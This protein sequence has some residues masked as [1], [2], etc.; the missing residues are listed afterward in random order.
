MKST[1]IKQYLIDWNYTRKFRV[2]RNDT[3]H[4][5]LDR[6]ESIRHGPKVTPCYKARSYQTRCIVSVC[7]MLVGDGAGGHL[8]AA[9]GFRWRRLVLRSGGSDS[10]P[11]SPSPP[12]PSP[13]PDRRLPPIRLQVLVY[14]ATQL[15]HTSTV[16]FLVHRHVAA[17]QS[18]AHA[19]QGARSARR[20]ARGRRARVRGVLR[21]EP[22]HVRHAREARVRVRTRAFTFNDCNGC[23][24]H[25][26]NE[27]RE[28]RRWGAGGVRRGQRRG[29]SGECGGA[30]A[31][32][33]D[34]RGSSGTPPDWRSGTREEAAPKAAQPRVLTSPRRIIRGVLCCFFFVSFRVNWPI[35]T[36]QWP[37]QLIYQFSD[38]SW[39][40]LLIS[41]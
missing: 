39:P 40:G 1:N 19:Q 21:V 3:R 36:V 41:Q 6:V 17:H 15:L 5:L 23:G 37:L 7:Y 27:Q 9:L 24:C 33:A 16:S 32:A 22:H 25:W 8:A 4:S 34:T 11:S 12:A 18:D 28:A 29:R 30:G 20:R 35:E 2:D 26:C 13:S 31:R 10:A 38:Y 14:P